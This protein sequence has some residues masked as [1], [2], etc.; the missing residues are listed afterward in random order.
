MW[1]GSIE[2]VEGKTDIED[3]SIEQLSNNLVSAGLPCDLASLRSGSPHNQSP[4]C[5]PTSENP[6]PLAVRLFLS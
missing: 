1:L 6:A 2:A 5:I 3:D 4:F